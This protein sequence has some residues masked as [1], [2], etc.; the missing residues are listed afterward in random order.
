MDRQTLL[1][2]LAT[3]LRAAISFISQYS[4]TIRSSSGG[5]A[6]EE[7]ELM[8]IHGG[9][10]SRLTGDYVLGGQYLLWVSIDVLRCV[11]RE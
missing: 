10:T 1:N 6:C 5:E 7:T 9:L 11:S 8:V 2:F 4:M 3:P